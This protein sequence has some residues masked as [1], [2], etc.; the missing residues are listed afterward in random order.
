MSSNRRIWSEEAWNSFTT[1]ARELHQSGLRGDA[2]WK[3]LEQALVA[4]Y[5]SAD[6]LDHAQVHE[7][8]MRHLVFAG[9]LPTS[10]AP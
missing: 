3:R 4:V 8:A 1:E 10:A 2:L 5:A 6:P 9:I 7:D